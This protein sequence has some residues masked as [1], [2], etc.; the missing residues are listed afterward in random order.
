[1]GFSADIA[2]SADYYSYAVSIATGDPILKT[3]IIFI[4]SAFWFNVFGGRASKFSS[5]IKA[6]AAFLRDF[7]IAFRA[8]G[9][10]NLLIAMGTFHV[11]HLIEFHYHSNNT[12]SLIHLHADVNL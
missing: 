4:C 5:T 1:M 10:Q 12:T 11:N 7:L 6:I 3:Y 2:L 9:A 8:D